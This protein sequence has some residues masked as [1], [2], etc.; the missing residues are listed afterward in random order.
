MRITNNLERI[1]DEIEVLA[2]LIERLIGENFYFSEEGMQDYDRMA[3]EV[4]HFLTLV[5]GAFITEDP[6]VMPEALEIE[7][8]VNQMRDD[9]KSLHI[10]RLQMGVC[11]VDSGLVFVDILTTFEKMGGCCFNI[12]Q[13]VA[14]IK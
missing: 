2:K 9:L 10:A 12:A 13:S 5:N 1:G 6:G 8:T 4:R 3:Q 7:K 14:G 11:V